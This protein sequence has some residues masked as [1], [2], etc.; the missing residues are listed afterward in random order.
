VL[1]G[2]ASGEATT[3]SWLVAEEAGRDLASGNTSER[4]V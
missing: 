3:A 2:W 4:G 1:S